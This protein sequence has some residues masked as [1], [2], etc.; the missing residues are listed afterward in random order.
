VPFDAVH[1]RIADELIEDAV[2]LHAAI[3]WHP[4]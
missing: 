1:R 4:A 2:E 3:G